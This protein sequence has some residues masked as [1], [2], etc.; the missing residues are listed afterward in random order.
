MLKTC[1]KLGE[2]PAKIRTIRNPSVEVFLDSL[3]NRLAKFLR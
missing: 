3:T 2:N 1:A